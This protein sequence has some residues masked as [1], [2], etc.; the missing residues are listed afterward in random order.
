MRAAAK[1]RTGV[2]GIGR[3]G[4]LRLLGFLL[5]VACLGCQSRPIPAGLPLE[6]PPITDLQ[7]TTI[8]EVWLPQSRDGTQLSPL[9]ID[10]IDYA[11]A[12]GH[13]CVQMVHCF[14]NPDEPGCE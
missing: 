1:S 10:T 4:W 7:A 13:R 2:C 6:C 3:S 14:R 5:A 9:A 8:R 11:V 12:A